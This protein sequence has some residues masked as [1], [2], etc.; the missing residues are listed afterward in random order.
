[1]T[2]HRFVPDPTGFPGCAAHVIGPD[3]RGRTCDLP[4][5]HSVHTPKPGGTAPVAGGLY[6]AA[7]AGPGVVG[8]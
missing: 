6:S 8:A 4:E 2:R 7:L 5:G 3:G 1:M